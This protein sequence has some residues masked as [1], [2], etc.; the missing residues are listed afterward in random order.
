MGPPPMRI[1]FVLDNSVSMMCKAT[2]L[3]AMSALDSAK[4]TIEQFVTT[5]SRMLKI[6]DHYAL[7]TCDGV[8]TEWN[9]STDQFLKQLRLIRSSNLASISSALDSGFEFVNKYRAPS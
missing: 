5:R 6:S 9:C 3:G 8:E 7:V 4:S 2:T 1:V